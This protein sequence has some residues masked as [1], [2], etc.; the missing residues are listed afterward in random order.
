M[1][2]G[3]ASSPA[4][5]MIVAQ[6]KKHPAAGPEQRGDHEEERASR[7]QPSQ[8]NSSI[9]RLAPQSFL[10]GAPGGWQI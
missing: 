5:P 4:L 2:E 7:A 10:I 9:K 1:E 8:G 3:L 6:A